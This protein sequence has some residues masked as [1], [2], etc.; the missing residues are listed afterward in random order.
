MFIG[1]WMSGV[2]DGSDAA[3]DRVCEKFLGYDVG[4]H[5]HQRLGVLPMNFSNVDVRKTNC[6]N[7][8][9]AD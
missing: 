7:S 9:Y 8:K 1:K 2:M 3:S 4:G 5:S 6:L